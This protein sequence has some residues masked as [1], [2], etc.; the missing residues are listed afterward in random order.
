MATIGWGGNE[1]VDGWLVVRTRV[2]HDPR[3]RCRTE[4]VQSQTYPE[5]LHRT[6]YQVPGTWYTIKLHQNVY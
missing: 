6:A 1:N 4:G 3:S 5:G 2:E